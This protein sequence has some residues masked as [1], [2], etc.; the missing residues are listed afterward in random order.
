MEIHMLLLGD[1]TGRG[2]LWDR[3]DLEHQKQKPDS[4]NHVLLQEIS[5][6]SYET[7]LQH[8][9]D[10]NQSQLSV[11]AEVQANNVK[12]IVVPAACARWPFVKIIYY[13]SRLIDIN[14]N[15]FI[16]FDCV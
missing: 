12:Y 1:A 5:L 4:V 11:L 8:I 9:A 15:I 16:D 13:L 2:R 10:S 6:N 14:P 3:A 7:T